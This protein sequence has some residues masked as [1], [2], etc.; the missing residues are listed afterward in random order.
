MAFE[1]YLQDNNIRNVKRDIEQ[2]S[3]LMYTVTTNRMVGA[4]TV[5][6]FVEICEDYFKLLHKFENYFSVNLGLLRI[7]EDFHQVYSLGVFGYNANSSLEQPFLQNF[8]DFVGNT[9]ETIKNSQF[10]EPTSG[11]DTKIKLP[12]L[13]EFS[14]LQVI[15]LLLIGVWLFTVLFGKQSRSA[16]RRSSASELALLAKALKK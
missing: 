7:E 9:E 3:S 16:R 6:Y 15:L 8:L 1:Q 10:T 4:D 2:I 5:S 12:F 11:F 14:I 13:G